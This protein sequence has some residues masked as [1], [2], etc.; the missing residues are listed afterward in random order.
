M[1]GKEVKQHNLPSVSGEVNLPP[2]NC[3]DPTLRVS[4]LL[5]A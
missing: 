2:V 3:I 1:H 5:R 4:I